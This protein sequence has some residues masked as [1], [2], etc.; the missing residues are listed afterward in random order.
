MNNNDK[1][2]EIKERLKEL[3]ILENK[4]REK[5]KKLQ[6][7][8][9]ILEAL[10][11]KETEKLK[12]HIDKKIEKSTYKKMKLT[13]IWWLMVLSIVY[14]FSQ[15]KVQEAISTIIK[16]WPN[17]FIEQ[18]EN[19]MN[20]EEES[21]NAIK[22]IEIKDE[23]KKD[24]FIIKQL[25]DT[26]LDDSNNF[27]V[28]LVINLTKE[29][30]FNYRNRGETKDL[31][32]TEGAMISTFKPFYDSKTYKSTLSQ[33]NDQSTVIALNTETGMISAGTFIEFK[34]NPDYVVSETRAPKKVVDVE[35]D[36][37]SKYIK[38]IYQQWITL[39][40]ADSSKTTF[41]I[42][43]GKDADGNFLWWYSG[44]KVLIF[45]EDKK[46]WWFIYGTAKMIKEQ[47]REF[48]ETYNIK[49]VLWYDL[50]QKSYSQTIQTKNKKITGEELIRLDNFNSAMSGS[51]NILYL[52]NNLH[53]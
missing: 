47:V 30:R 48:K 50:D 34:D 13:V 17:N 6:K 52:D 27:R 33:S 1:Q 51:G 15:E 26:I 41:P 11:Q 9:E 21:E 53:K 35:I 43:I 39:K 28:P 49:Y 32:N 20:Q 16:E 4:E 2:Q 8:W 37:Q 23:N 5:L 31:N 45:S 18:T 46:H 22:I 36:P 40:L 44:W 38:N 12:N 14:W 7:K 19:Y 24:N 42:W 3:D 29:N 10:E 25:W